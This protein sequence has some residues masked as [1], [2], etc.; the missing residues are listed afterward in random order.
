V[1]RE[2]PY[3]S[4]AIVEAMVG[5]VIVRAASTANVMTVSAVSE[6]AHHPTSLWVSIDR[7]TYTH[8][9]LRQGGVFTLA[10]LHD[11]QAELAWA[12]GTV[13]GR[14]R[15]KC[16]TLALS[17]R[18]DCLFLP[19]ALTNTACRIRTTVDLGTHTMFIADLLSGEVNS[20]L[21]HRRN[22]LLSDL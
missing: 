15:D 2:S 3:V 11:G 10:L 19:E 4:A 22:L 20:R 16:A 21:Q 8:E 9:L 6:V 5:L 17:A 1:V 7:T 13:S 12:C 14:D 18:T